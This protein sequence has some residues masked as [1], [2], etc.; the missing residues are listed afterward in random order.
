[1]KPREILTREHVLQALKDLES[2]LETRWGKSLKFD[3]VYEGK[4]FAPKAALGR[5]ICIAAGASEDAIKI[6]GGE[7]TNG[8]L[9]HLG[10]TVE[11]KE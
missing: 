2:G 6:T 11:P 9:K 3:L 5:A 8:I 10:F 4:R 1:M 7:A